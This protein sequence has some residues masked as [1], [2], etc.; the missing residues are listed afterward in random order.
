MTDSSRIQVNPMRPSIH[1]LCLVQGMY[2]LDIYGQITPVLYGFFS[3]YCGGLWLAAL[4]AM[5][6]MAQSIGKLED[7]DFYQKLL[8]RG[9]ESYSK[10]LWNGKYYNFDCSSKQYNSIMADQLNGHWYLGC[11]GEAANYP[12]SS[13]TH[14]PSE[15]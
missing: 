13:L 12:V 14:R 1:G 11:I 6:K 5:T 10:K 15:S 4:Y 9:V 8:L 7:K 2:L 3:S